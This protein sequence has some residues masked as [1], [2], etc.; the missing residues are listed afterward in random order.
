MWN[1]RQ[2]ALD[3]EITAV[4]VWPDMARDTTSEGYFGRVL[5]RRDALTFTFVLSADEDVGL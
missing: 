5:S 3:M 2:N 4:F 1:E